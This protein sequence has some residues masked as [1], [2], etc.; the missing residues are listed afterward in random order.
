MTTDLRCSR[1]FLGLWS[2]T[3]YIPYLYIVAPSLTRGEQLRVCTTV[4]LYAYCRLV[5]QRSK[6]PHAIGVRSKIRI[7]ILSGTTLCNSQSTRMVNFR[8]KTH[9]EPHFFLPTRKQ[10]EPGSEL[11]QQI[12]GSKWG[13]STFG[14]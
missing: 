8:Q 13:P 11:A 7:I 2:Y 12:L 10:P 1:A 5:Q 4:Q 6:D 3:P 9:V 14:L